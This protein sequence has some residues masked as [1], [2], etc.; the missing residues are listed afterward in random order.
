MKGP[1]SRRAFLGGA[2]AFA[3]AAPALANAPAQSL[4]PV[5][6]GEMLLAMAST[7]PEE[8]IAKAKLNGQV[9]YCVADVATGEIIER[10]G[11]NVGLPPASVAKAITAAYALEVLGPDHRF[12]TRL[13]AAGPVVD[14]VLKGDLILAGGADPTL[15][16]DGLHGLANALKDA[17]ITGVEGGFLV[18]GGGLP[19]APAIDAAQPDHVG[20]NPAVSGLNLNFNR[21]HFEWRRNGSNY[22]VSMDARSRTLRPDVH[23]A[24]MKVITR[25][26]PIYTYED[27]GVSDNW[28][29][30]RGALG[31]GGA[32]WLP[33]RKPEIYAG[34]VFQTFA[35]S[36]GIELSAA[37][38]LADLPDG[39]TELAAHV[40]APL[41]VILRDMLKFSTNL[42]A[43][44][45][46]MAT[47]AA[48]LGE[49]TSFRMS[50]AEMSAWANES[51]GTDGIALVDHS[52]LGDKS[53]VEAPDMVALLVG[54]RDRLEMQ[55]LLKEI[56][57][58]DGNR[59][60]VQNHPAKVR[61]KTGTLNFVSGLAGYLDG[62]DGKT[63]AFA[64][65]AADTDRRDGLTKDERENPPGAASW[66]ARAKILQ[67]KLLDR[68]FALHAS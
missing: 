66:N 2:A 44:V 8:L 21:V 31:N 30:A 52:G 14:G 40:S 16:T 68:W 7:P 28:T 26:V 1:I 56:P 17:G 42:T 53:R 3:A 15:D 12:R 5:A 10:M 63:L 50:A 47:T 57:M 60:I 62:A 6:R 23:V 4:R 58:R 33:V 36:V 18:F 20:Y 64:I 13:L 27:S 59:K 35:R 22:A 38:L 46:G 34:E 45:V 43:E 39:V 11:P 32:R 19:T 41:A 29:V 49:V 37:K 51:F 65:F 9:T 55:P 61:A 67:Q 54:V 25:D 24:R 48:R